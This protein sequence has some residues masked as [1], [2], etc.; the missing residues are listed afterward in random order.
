MENIPNSVFATDSG[1]DSVSGGGVVSYNMLSALAKMSDVKGVFAGIDTKETGLNGTVIKSIKP[2]VYGYPPDPPFMKDY[3]TC[4]FMQQ[5]GHPIELFVTYACPFGMSAK[6]LELKYRKFVSIV[7]DLAP[8][9]I[10]LSR[11][12]HEKF[13]APYPYPHLTD[14]MMLKL[15]TKHLR[16]ADKVIVH[17]LSG[18]RYV[19]SEFN[20]NM[21]DIVVLPHGIYYPETIPELPQKVYNDRGGGLDRFAVGYFGSCGLDKGISYLFNA[22]QGNPTFDLVVGG[23]GT[24]GLEGNNKLHWFTH[25]GEG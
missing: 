11:E 2:E 12:E 19:S 14:E 10:N 16:L 24:K 20:V 7:C 25:I 13:N 6:F 4:S 3:L 17:S 21:D 5:I 23:K 9:N 15:Y 18:E 8:H 22:V 1:I